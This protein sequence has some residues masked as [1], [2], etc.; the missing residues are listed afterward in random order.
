M[1]LAEGDDPRVR[2]AADRLVDLGVVPILLCDDAGRRDGLDERVRLRSIDSLA[3]SRVG[4]AVREGFAGGPS[5]QADERDDPARHPVNLAAALV[6]TGEADAC[7]AGCVDPTAT[8]LRAALKVVGLAPGCTTVSSSFLLAMPDDRVLCFAD[9]AVVPEPTTEQLVDIAVSSAATFEQLAGERPVVAMLSF[10]SK[11]S[12]E[13]ASITKV[14]S[15]VDLVSF[16]HPD[17]LVDGEL[18][19]DAALL[20]SVGQAKAP[21]SSVAGR[22]NVFVFPDLAAGNIGYKIAH[23]LGGAQAYGPILQG[24]VAPMNDLSR[25]CSVDEI[26]NVVALSAVQATYTTGEHL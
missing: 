10:S 24:L 3:S 13:H 8:V 19:F 4:A 2:E 25:G 23:R 12:A 18:Q 15:A 9:C 6:A 14:R 1:V 11:G 7:V 5:R 20:E 16:A 17:L 26:V 21:G 22:A